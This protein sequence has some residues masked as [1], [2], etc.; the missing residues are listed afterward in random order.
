MLRT[1]LAGL[2]AHPGRL[3]ATVLAVTLGVSFGCGTLIF[4]DTV[5]VSFFDEFARAARNVDVVLLP[6]QGS[7]SSASGNA[8]SAAGSEAEPT[9]PADTLAA[10]LA[11]PG[12]AAA[13]GR[14]AT[15]LPLLDSGG[16]LLR[17]GNSVGHAI[18]AGSDPLLRQ[19]DVTAGRAPSAD[20]E[21]AVDEKTAARA[22]FTIGDSITVLDT[23]QR[24][25]QL[26]LVGTFRLAVSSFY[27][28]HSVVALTDAPMVAL[29]RPTGY[30]EIVV[31]ASPGTAPAALA[32]RLAAVPPSGLADVHTGEQRRVDLANQA[33]K[34]VDLL[35]FALSIFGL[36]ALV[37]SAFVIFNTFTILLA[38]R[39]RELAMLRC[40][41][42]SRRQIFGS[43]LLEAAVIGLVGGVLG[44]AVG[45]GIAY[46]MFKA[47][48][49]L[50][51]QLP[52]HP[53]VLGTGPILL[54]LILGVGVTVL[55]AGVPAARAT[56]IA[57]LAALRTD[58]NAGVR[59]VHGRALRLV[60]G[61]LAV[62]VG[63]VA[64][65]VGAAS[66]DRS[67]PSGGVGPGSTAETLVV[68]GGMI[69]FLGLL[70]VTPL[71]IGP[72][73]TLLG[74]APSRLFGTPVRL[75]TVNVR[76]N[77]A[78]AA[79]TTATLMVGVGLMSVFSV[80]LAT[81]AATF[82]SKLDRQL[83]IDYAVESADAGPGG[84]VPSTVLDGLRGRPEFDRVIGV[85]R[86]DG[87][88]DKRRTTVGSVDHTGLDLL[89][90]D[91]VAGRVA[92]LGP[93]TVVLADS[94]A[95]KAGKRVGDEV[96]V[97]VG[98][99]SARYRIVATVAENTALATVVL[100]P[101]EFAQRYDGTLSVLLRAKPGVN[102]T[103]SR[104]A[105]EG[106]VA[107]YPLLRVR[108]VADFREELTDQVNALLGFV[109]GLLG[110]TFLISLVG[111]AN[112]LSLSIVERSRES[113]MLRALGLTRGQLRATLLVEALLL[114]C[115][116][117]L[118]GVAFGLVYGVLLTRATFTPNTPVLT[119]PAGQLLAYVAVAATAGALAAVLPANRAQRVSIVSA[120]HS[121]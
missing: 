19:Y 84:G 93:G 95:A 73:T 89:L 107:G 112:T 7:G 106:I 28:G 64:G 26:T 48:G 1:T 103:D 20:G 58:P 97:A 78:R 59:T 44:V 2:R 108:S 101:Q 14:Y 35:L 120:M 42:A 116:G 114:A 24:P 80:M 71:F 96:T 65:G 92:D 8:S 69:A 22:R 110:V 55:S 104:A 57:P 109:A 85:R 115:S 46:A 10:V 94:A 98:D 32:G 105:V 82:N 11:E 86:A 43:V 83:P 54:A 74:A 56:R 47:F 29:T 51:L 17:N 102:S 62:L 33:I 9:L 16:R 5:K 21:A 77:P 68:G 88:L 75:A 31:R 53:P 39:I 63:G 111:I 119:V 79:A 113:A 25:H 4:G 76:R 52:F 61:G 121:C 60:F 3:V 12:V 40:V 18:S 23:D 66:P 87:S 81:S 13:E 38:Q 50:G 117:A 41:G 72:L 67:G 37:V 100:D 99:G 36:V 91:T 15:R 49:W 118:V 6:H 45:V 30:A 27:S 70:I 34:D 90:P